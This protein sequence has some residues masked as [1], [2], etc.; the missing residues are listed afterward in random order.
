MRIWHKEID[1]AHAFYA[2]GLLRSLFLSMTSIFVPIFI[3]N[4]SSSLLMVIGYYILQRLIV[5]VVVFPVSRVIEKIG[6]R[7]SI[8][9]SVV[10]LIISTVSLMMTRQNIWW[11]LLSVV[12]EGLQVAFYWIARDSALSQDFDTKHM[13]RKVSYLV[14]LENIA[15]LLGPFAGGVILYFSGFQTLFSFSVIILCLSILPLWRMASHSHKN[16]V[17]LGGFWY[18]VTNG[19]NR[20]QVV[21]NFGASMNDY[22]NGVVWPLIL[23]FG[24]ISTTSLGVIY[25]MVAVMA[26]AMQ[27]MTGA[28]FD[29]LRARNDFADEGVY[30]FAV[31]GVSFIWIGRFF[32][33]GL[34]QV[35]PLDIVR[36][37]FSSVQANFYSDYLHLGGKR[38]GSIAYWVYMEVVYSMGAIFLFTLMG[39]GIYFSIWRELVIGT[40]ALWSLATMVIARESNL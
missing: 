32:V 34:S 12:T 30:G 35:L 22:G 2:N 13:G 33:H 24:G 7:H 1:G 25:S 27:Y 29:K 19:R 15:S 16:G 28:W 20:H 37:L 23:F 8:A 3:Y 18:F 31:V 10:F 40:I 39:I 9:Y 4:L 11:L 14:V 26:I 38:A 6:F 21:A 5:S 17:S 36:Q